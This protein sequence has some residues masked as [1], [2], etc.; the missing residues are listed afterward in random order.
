VFSLS[1]MD[2][3]V[4]TSATSAITKGKIIKLSHH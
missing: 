4:P 2:D 1:L 3:F